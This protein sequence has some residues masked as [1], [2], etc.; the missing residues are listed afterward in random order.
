MLIQLK[1]LEMNDLTDKTKKNRDKKL[2]KSGYW[3]LCSIL[4]KTRYSNLIGDFEELYIEIHHEKGRFAALLWYWRQIF[5][6]LPSF[7]TGKIA[8]GWSMFKNY[9]KVTL[10]TLKRKKVYSFLNITGLALG[11][12]SSFILMLW[13]Y[14][15]WSF[16]RFH[17]NTNEIF[18]IYKIVE[19]GD[20]ISLEA[21]TLAPIAPTLKR[22]YPEVVNSTRFY[23][24]N[25]RNVQY[26]GKNFRENRVGTADPSFFEIFTFPFIEGDP[27][28]ALNNLYSVV[29]TEQMAEKCFGS[30]D[31]IGKTLKMDEWDFTVTGI[32]KNVPDNSGIKFDCIIPY[33]FWKVRDYDIETWHEYGLENYT[34][35]QLQKDVDYKEVEKKT[36]GIVKKHLQNAKSGI[37]LQPLK[38]M[39]LYSDFLFDSVGGR[40]SIISVYIFLSLS[41]FVLVIACINYMNLSTARS[42]TR[43]R[44]VGLRKVIGAQRTDLIKQFFGE[45]LFFS[46]LSMLLTVLLLWLLL[47]AFNRISGKQL[48][49]MSYLSNNFLLVLGL[50]IMP[51]VTGLLSGIYPSVF[52]SAF[53]PEKIIRGTFLSGRGDR[54]FR[55]TLVIIQF[56][57]MTVLIIGA[58]VIFNQL[59][60]ISYK[61]LGFNKDNLAYVQGLWDFPDINMNTVKN[62]LVKING[63]NGISCGDR[64]VWGGYVTTNLDWEGKK[65]A[66]KVPMHHF[67]MG[68]NYIETYQM[69]LKE[70]RSFSEKFAADINRRSFILNESAVRA[71][72]LS[73]K[74]PIGLQFSLNRQ[75]GTII[76]VL[77]D[78]HFRTL[79]KVIE[80][81]VI[82]MS[83]NSPVLFVRISPENIEKTLGSIRDC[84]EKIIPEYEFRYRFLSE[85]LNGM[86]ISEYK[87][88][89]I[90]RYFTF[91][92]IVIACLGLFGL[93]VFTAE[94]RLKEIGIRKVLGSSNLKILLMLISE[95]GRLIVAATVIAWP[96]GFYVMQKWLE[97]FAYRINLDFFIFVESTIITLIAALLT[98][99]IISI[100]SAKTNPVKILRDE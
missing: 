11:M 24:T 23:H 95:Q 61:D 15:E 17:E 55:K 82:T 12:T 28:T 35:I 64:P 3:F 96:A 94:Q 36:A 1:A 80:P 18:R 38:K 85:E 86:Y 63:I 68:L 59:T 26:N 47:P 25:F 43:A 27:K 100:K 30:L 91:L 73:K 87:T 42:L 20:N 52:L 50:L 33:A 57:L 65:S 78:F 10:R 4:G 44:E 76:G 34:F 53:Q 14:D 97:N 7:F 31:A 60:Y 21:R 40:G 75:E 71:M 51:I 98:V 22:D 92:T 49:L 84:F 93:T 2:S 58:L 41:G 37:A 62:E 13:V 88:N 54:V 67:S 32:I 69:R 83:S 90:F 8:G 39:H 5:R 9:I 72:E 16:D 70:G 79:H 6:S 56:S 45:S 81:M 89:E 29:L 66:D 46:I 77:E 99:G 19:N 48:N 74:S